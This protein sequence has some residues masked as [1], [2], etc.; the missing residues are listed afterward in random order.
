MNDNELDEMLDLMRPKPCPLVARERFK[1][2]PDNQLFLQQCRE[3]EFDISAVIN[4]AL[5]VI[6]PKF[7]P[8]GATWESLKKL[9]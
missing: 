4:L 5:S 7:T 8:A 3:Q 2:T 6:K 9:L 1:P